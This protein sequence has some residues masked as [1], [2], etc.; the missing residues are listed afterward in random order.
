V[1]VRASHT[2]VKL[3]QVGDELFVISSR[4]QD[5][6]RSKAQQN[7]SAALLSEL[8]A[9]ECCLRLAFLLP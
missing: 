3:G 2:S 1:L 9:G 7:L 4:L 6:G 8:D 5:M